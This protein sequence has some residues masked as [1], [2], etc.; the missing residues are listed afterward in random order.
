MDGNRHERTARFGIQFLE[1]TEANRRALWR[2]VDTLRDALPA[3]L[4]GDSDGL[5][6]TAP[7]SPRTSELCMLLA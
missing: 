7:P 6:N 4:S 5:P 3:E 2:T 1:V